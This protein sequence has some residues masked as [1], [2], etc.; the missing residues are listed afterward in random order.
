MLFLA[1]TSF[2]KDVI[3]FTQ[4]NFFSKFHILKFYMGTLDVWI[5]FFWFSLSFGQKIKN[6]TW[7]V[8]YKKHC[9]HLWDLIVGTYLNITWQPCETEATTFYL[10]VLIWDVSV[11]SG[12]SFL[13]KYQTIFNILKKI[14]YYN[15]YHRIRPLRQRTILKQFNWI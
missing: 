12:A 10:T 7:C 2:C 15:M 11:V 14:C 1:M 5:F 9:E 4:K 3:F 13:T 8:P 6:V